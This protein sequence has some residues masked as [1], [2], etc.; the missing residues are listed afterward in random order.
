MKWVRYTAEQRQWA[1]SQ[2]GPPVNRTIRSL[3]LATGITEVSLRTWRNAALIE[4]LLVRKDGKQSER[5]SGPE[6]F[7]IVVESAP[8]NAEELSAYC[9]QRGLLPDQIQ[10]WRTA[11]EQANAPMTTSQG[12]VK[13]DSAMARDR[14]KMLEREIRRKDAALA[15]T[16]ALL[17]L[18]KKADAI[19]GKD[20]D[21]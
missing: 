16:A 19:W 7:R 17:V 12:V 11:C 15:E 10:Q 3:A 9:R 2:M 1:V 18:R 21:E 20:E 13:P 4:G 5:W 6:K 14:I 8:L